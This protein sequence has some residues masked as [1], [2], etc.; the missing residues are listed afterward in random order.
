MGFKSNFIF[1]IFI[2]F[3]S[4]LAYSAYLKVE[5]DLMLD[6]KKISIIES[7]LTETPNIIGISERSYL[8]IR[9]EG[10]KVESYISTPTYNGSNNNVGLRW[11]SDKPV[12]K[13]W[14]ESTSGTAFFVPNPKVFISKILESDTLVFQWE[15]Y[16]KQ[17]QATKFRLSDL[18]E[19][20]KEASE[21]GCKI[22][23]D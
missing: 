22:N 19:K 6:I 13:R 9:C 14:N 21:K 16:Q 8:Q 17:K 7:S 2:T 23:L 10:E 3:F 11:N 1:F 20:I 18:K 15:P 5:D 12:Y 4:P